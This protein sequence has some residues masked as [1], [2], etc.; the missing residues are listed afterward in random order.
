MVPQSTTYLIPGMVID[1]SAIFVEIIINL[2][3]EGWEVNACSV[4]YFDWFD[5]NA[6]ILNF[7]GKE[8]LIEPDLELLTIFVLS[9]FGLNYSSSFISE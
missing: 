3:S 1:V 8:E 7:K 9:S 4:F 6:M 5:Y 2:T